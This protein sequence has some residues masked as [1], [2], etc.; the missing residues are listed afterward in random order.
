MHI[1]VASSSPRVEENWVGP[2]V[3]LPCSCVETFPF[4]QPT[5]EQEAAIGEAA[6]KLDRLRNNWLN[7]PEWSREE[8]LEF[9]GSADAPWARYVHDPDR[10]G[11][12]TVRYPRL[13]AKDAECAKL[14]A[15]RTLTNL[16]NQRPTWLDLA[17]K[18]LHEAVFAA[19]G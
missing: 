1:I 4:P 15:A 12:G 17:H 8:V 16:Y 19:Y 6:K 9:P 2:V 18:K 14:F 11:I 7:P 10:R 5:P 3:L 13:V